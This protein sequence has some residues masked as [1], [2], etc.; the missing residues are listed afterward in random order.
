MIDERYRKIQK[1]GEGR[2][3]VVYL[4]DDVTNNRT[5]ALKLVHRDYV[6]NESSV[7]RFCQEMRLAAAL[8]HPN[9]IQIYDFDRGADGNFY[10]AME[11]VKGKSLKEILRAGSLDIPRVVHLAIQIA[12]GL[13]VAH[14]VGLVHGD[15]KPG[16]VMV[17][18]S[19]DAVKVMD[20]GIARLGESE[21][22]T[23][24]QRQIPAGTPSYMAPEQIENREVNEKT[25]IYAFGIVLYEMITGMVPFRAPTP[26]AVL[27]KHSEEEPVR[28]GTLRADVPPPLERVI[29][30]AMEKKP[31][32]R[33][34]K[35]KDIADV[36]RQVENEF[37][38]KTLAATM[39]LTQPLSAVTQLRDNQETHSA[40]QSGNPLAGSLANQ[41]ESAGAA[42][43]MMEKSDGPG[44]RTEFYQLPTASQPTVFQAID[45]T[46]PIEKSRQWKV[47]WK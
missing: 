43:V 45:R 13:N 26:E 31:E 5:V 40:P 12:D 10:I 25:D 38:Q 37:S 18:E 27:K 47:N 6:H 2:R 7:L 17:G 35:M 42:T 1:I 44:S 19:S 9:V 32:R 28:P 30:E 29:M 36:L 34:A 22:S 8:T 14:Q 15:V 20:F 39:M 16:A 11:Y 3:S 24:G 41:A 23:P 46:V 4:A 21:A 33:P